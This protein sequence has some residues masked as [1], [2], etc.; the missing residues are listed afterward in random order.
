MKILF[1]G[2]PAYAIPSLDALVA[3]GHHV[4]GV[5]TQ[6]D[7]RRGRGKALQPSP[8]KVRALELG[9]PV[10]TPERIRREPEC[11]AQLAAL[12]ADLDVVVAFGQ[13][14]PPEVLAHPPLGCWNGHGSLLPR[15]RGAGPIQWCLLEGDAETG[16][17]IM[18]MEEGL[19]TGPVLLERRLPIGLLEN[20]E[21]LGQ[22]LSQLTAELLIESLP[23]IEA[24]GTGPEAQRLQRLGV[25]T[26]S[27]EGMT[28]ARMLTKDDLQIDWVSSALTLHRQV[29]GLYP[30]AVSQWRG[31]RLKLLATEPLVQRL[32]DQLS[33]PGAAL[34]DRWSQ[35]PTTDQRPAVLQADPS[36]AG[37]PEAPKTQS[38]APDPASEMVP[39][40]VLAVEQGVGLVIATGGCPVLL[41]AAQLEGKAPAA[42]QSLLQQLGAQPGDCFGV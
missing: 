42:G 16:V 33:E 20:A 40:T 23:L 41:L 11:Q 34:C 39:G 13:I 31:K 6:P 26:Q 22:R 7:R 35:P 27:E 24:A 28:Y 9:L 21:H 12:G 3:A 15:W 36:Q 18:A 10:F 4:V 8:V 1:W 17:G 14:L 32:R 25:R 29:M 37:L 30:G 5:V 2:T 19:D 38:G